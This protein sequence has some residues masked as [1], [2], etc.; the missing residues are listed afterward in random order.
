MQAENIPVANKIARISSLLKPVIVVLGAIV[1]LV[2]VTVLV[3]LAASPTATGQSTLLSDAQSIHDLNIEL[4]DISDGNLTRGDKVLA[5]V[6]VVT[7][8]VLATLFAINVLRLLRGFARGHVFCEMSIRCARNIGFVF[9]AAFAAQL[10]GYWVVAIMIGDI[11]LRF[12]FLYDV[13]IIGFV[14]LCVWILEIG[15]ALY[16]ENEMTI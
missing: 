9:V 2:C 5:T 12:N 1:V 11:Q 13:L 3:Q 4:G 15:V 14:W 6:V 16:T 10:I 8:I 7:I